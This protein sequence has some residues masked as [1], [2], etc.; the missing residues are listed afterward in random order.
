MSEKQEGKKK[1]QKTA[2]TT[3]LWVKIM[4]L[5]IALVMIG[6]AIPLTMFMLWN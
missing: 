1:K 5:A 4:A 6:S 3:P 2:S